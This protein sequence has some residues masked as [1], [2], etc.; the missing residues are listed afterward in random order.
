DKDRGDL[1]IQLNASPGNVGAA[2]TI[3]R[4]ELERL[5]TT[6][7]SQDELTE[8]K[9]RLVSEALLDEASASGQR[10]ELL[11]IGENHLPLDYFATLS[12]RYADITPTDV[13]RVAKEYLQPDRLIEVFAGP[14]GPWSS[15]SL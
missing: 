15:G 2:V 6:P 10:D 12:T 7:I 3:V 8:A 11:E 1:E 5:R 4:D 9:V 13:Q 14:V